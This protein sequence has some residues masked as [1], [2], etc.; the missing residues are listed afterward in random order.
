V[1][2]A[3][4]LV[5]PITARASPP[6]LVIDAFDGGMPVAADASRPAVRIRIPATTASATT[7]STTTTTTV[8]KAGTML[9]PMQPTPRCDILDSFGDVRSG[10]A[11]EG[12]DI[13]ATLGQEVYALADGT[14]TKQYLDAVE[15]LAGNGWRLTL[16]DRTFYAFFHLSGFAPGLAQGSTVRRGDLIGYVGDTGNPGPGN[17]HLHFEYHPG[18]GS[19]VDPLPLLDIPQGC[20]VT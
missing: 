5:V 11:H 6:T 8:V 9:F 15:P 14:L 10:H 20:T 16:P 2:L 17:Y 4:G 1:A 3:V 12:V 13:L 18:G 19:A 7:T